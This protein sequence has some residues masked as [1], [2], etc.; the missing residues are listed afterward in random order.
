MP[1][2]DKN[3]IDYLAKLARIKLREEE[4][5]KFINDLRSILDYVTQL[6]QLDTENVEPAKH[7]LPYSNVCRKD[8][9]KASLP[10]EEVL[11]NAPERVKNMFKVPG[12]I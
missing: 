7:V 10:V 11:K 1:E 5:E 3:T 9:I 8:I 2:I 6:N 12:I 4:I